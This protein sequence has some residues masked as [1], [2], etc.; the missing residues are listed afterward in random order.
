MPLFAF[1]TSQLAVWRWT[2]F[3]SA[4]TVAA[5]E[6][7]DRNSRHSFMHC[8]VER[9]KWFER[10]PGWLADEGTETCVVSG[11][12]VFE[13]GPLGN[14]YESE[15]RIRSEG[16]MKLVAK[17]SSFAPHVRIYLLPQR[18]KFLL[19]PAGDF[20]AVDQGY[21]RHEILLVRDAITEFVPAISSRAS[22]IDRRSMVCDGSFC[23]LQAAGLR[24]PAHQRVDCSP[25]V[26]SFGACIGNS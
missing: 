24:K 15:A 21:C 13:G 14:I 8:F 1:W 4:L 26:Q 20:E 11:V 5:A 22:T 6:L 17:V 7:R 10:S 2:I 9:G 23:Q 3:G 19:T 12:E 18:E 16:T 25:L